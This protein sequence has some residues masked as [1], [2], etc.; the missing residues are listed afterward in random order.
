VN[1]VTLYGRTYLDA[2]VT[3]PLASLAEGKGK[4]DVEVMPMFG[5]F[6]CNAA[7]ALTGRLPP[8]SLHV[9]TVASSLDLP[10][11]RSALPDDVELDA[12][13][14]PSQAW[15][16]M[17]VIVNP[18][19]ECRLLRGAIDHN[20]DHWR[21][22]RVSAVAL[23]AALH[24]VGRL[25]ATFVG[26]L[27]ERVH[28]NGAR[29]AWVGGASLTREHEAAFDVI[30]VNTAE[31]KQLLGSQSDSP[32]E[33][34][35][36][37]AARAKTTDAVRLVTGRGSAPAAAAVRGSTVTV[38]EQA[39]API[40]KEQIRRLKG[41]GDVFAAHFVIDAVFDKQGALRTSLA[42][43]G[44]LESAHDVTSRYIQWGTTCTT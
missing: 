23:S 30:C 42:V 33:L 16:P 21:V 7:C 29:A 41:A 26:D 18:A 44:A 14:D 3:L 40:A 20:A 28:A 32:R 9:V 15:P 5:G 19:A 17:T 31:A 25:P 2:E 24:V 8:G 37:L 12:I 34:A 35:T 43:P 36:A 27:L 13:I 1:C 39:P 10:R 22:D 38:H 4:A 6:A 11:L